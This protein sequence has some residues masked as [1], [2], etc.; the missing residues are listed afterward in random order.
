MNIQIFEH[1][2]NCGFD[3][4]FKYLHEIVK[5]W[6]MKSAKINKSIYY[7]NRKLA[8]HLLNFWDINNLF[9]KKMMS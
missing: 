7:I 5:L 1:K 8:K 3:L 2:M 6:H 9:I 4:I